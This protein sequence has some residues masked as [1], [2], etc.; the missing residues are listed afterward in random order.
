M[1]FSL[2]V[3]VEDGE[4]SKSMCRK[5]GH[6]GVTSTARGANDYSVSKLFRLTHV[7]QQAGP[8]VHT[9]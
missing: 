1:S 6:N 9:I 2:R 7:D 4:A 3:G 5:S 8:I